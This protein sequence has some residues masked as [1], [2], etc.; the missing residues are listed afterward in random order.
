[1]KK[2]LISERIQSFPSRKHLVESPFTSNEYLLRV[3]LCRYS[4]QH[5]PLKSCESR[6]KQLYETNILLFL[7]RDRGSTQ[8]H[9]HVRCDPLTSRQFRSP[10][11]FRHLIAHL[12]IVKTF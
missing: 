2:I 11:R 6:L 4:Y 7:V 1:M 5:I 8:S 10:G 9:R 3:V 12:R